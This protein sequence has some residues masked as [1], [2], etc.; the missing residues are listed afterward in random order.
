MKKRKKINI[1]ADI[2]SAGASRDAA[3]QATLEVAKPILSKYLVH[4]NNNF[5]NLNL[6]WHVDI[7]I[8]VCETVS[9]TLT[10]SFC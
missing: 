1:E 5:L 9:Y 7:Q 2:G 10:Q 4:P 6:A 3:E 8:A